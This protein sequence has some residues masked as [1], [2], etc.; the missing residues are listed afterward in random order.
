MA[1]IPDRRLFLVKKLYYKKK[2]SARKIA[3]ILNTTL[4][5]MYYFMRKHNLVRR[6]SS[7]QNQIRFLNKKPSFDLRRITSLTLKELRVAGTFLYWAEGYKRGHLIDF[8]NSDVDMIKIFLKFLRKVCGVKESKIRIKIF[9]YSNHNIAKLKKFWSHITKI[10][11]SQFHKS[12]VRKSFNKKNQ[13]RLPY[14]LIH[15]I[16]SDKKL[17]LIIKQWIGHYIKKWADTRVVK[18]GAL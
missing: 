2:N 4:N 12:Y 14:G 5:S 17:L 16:Y 11:L 13:N 15:V 1:S 10:S 8:T 18:W 7:E 6:T 3:E 9:C